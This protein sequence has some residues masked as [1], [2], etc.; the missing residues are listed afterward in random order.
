MKLDLPISRQAS[1]P[2]TIVQRISQQAMRR[3]ALWGYL[4]IAPSIL[5]F[6]LF[7]YLA[8]GSSLFISF[9]QWDVLTA[10]QWIGLDNYV[11]LFKDPIFLKSLANTGIYTLISVPLGMSVSLGLAVALNTNIRFRNLY[12]LLFFLP[13]LTMPVS[14]SIVWKWLYNPTFGLFNQVLGLLGAAP[15]RWLSDP[16]MAMNSLVIMS[17]WMGSGY[18]MIIFL[19]GLQNIPREY[20]EAAQVDGANNATMFLHV[21]LPLLTPTILFS[22][23]TSLISAFQVFDIVYTMTKG[24]PL[25]ST[26]TVVY[27]IYEDGFHFFRMGTASAEAWILFVVILVITIIQMR[28]QRRWVHYQ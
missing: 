17:I 4:M 10:P 25:N 14:I 2:V 9:T 1:T 24:T 13:F 22:L 26:R 28:M 19:A 11:Q 3:E 15:V 20:Y 5:G 8:L 7:F 16:H 6:G 18:G 12:R 27:G 21:T 23:I